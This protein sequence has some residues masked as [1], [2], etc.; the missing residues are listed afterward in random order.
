MSEILPVVLCRVG[1]IANVVEVR[2]AD[3][4]IVRKLA[5]FGILPGTQIT[6]IQN[7]PAYVI[8]VEHT[9]LAVDRIIASTIFV[10]KFQSCT[11]YNKLFYGSWNKFVT[12]IKRM[13]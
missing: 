2:A 1:Q 12:L 8:R 4:A 11:D 7:S 6:I 13:L 10:K 9:E 5:A 3:E